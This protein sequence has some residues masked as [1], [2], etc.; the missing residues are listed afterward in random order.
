MSKIFAFAVVA[1]AGFTLG[2]PATSKACG[3]VYNYS[4]GCCDSYSTY[5]YST[6]AYYPST[7]CYGTPVTYT[8]YY[9]TP[10]SCWN[11]VA[12]CCQTYYYD[13]CCYTHTRR[14][15]RWR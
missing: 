1:V 11:Y 4:Y 13:P 9:S 10:S 15:G 14:F 8:Y 7:C 3:H 6:V 2:T 12:P 5:S